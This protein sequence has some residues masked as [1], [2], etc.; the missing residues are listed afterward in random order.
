MNFIH[1]PFETS[2]SKDGDK[3]PENTGFSTYKVKNWRDAQENAINRLI[4]Q[5]DMALSGLIAP[6]GRSGVCGSHVRKPRA[7]TRKK[8]TA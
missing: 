4:R 6:D 3:L 1:V 2:L 8:T 7:T 5:R